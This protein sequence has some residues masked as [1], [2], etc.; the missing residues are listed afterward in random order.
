MTGYADDLQ[1]AHA[2]R[3]SRPL[4]SAEVSQERWRAWK[5]QAID[6]A[7]ANCGSEQS[8]E[9][10]DWIGIGLHAVQDGVAHPGFPTIDEH[11]QRGMFWSDLFPSKQVTDGAYVASFEYL[12]EVRKQLGERAYRELTRW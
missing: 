4:E 11:G 7:K 8:G 3:Q 10:A 9:A 2:M 12:V 6:R 1:F 5:Q